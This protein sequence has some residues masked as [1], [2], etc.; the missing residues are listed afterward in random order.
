MT[1]KRTELEVAARKKK[2]YDPSYKLTLN[3]FGFY[4]KL[5][6]IVQLS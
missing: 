6:S 5:V 4:D 2:A 3:A 1:L